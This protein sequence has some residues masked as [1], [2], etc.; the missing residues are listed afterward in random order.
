MGKATEA[1]NTL[2]AVLDRMEVAYAIGG[3]VASSSH[4]VPRTTLD[5][6]IVVDMKLDQVDEFVAAV[7]DK[8]YADADMIREAFARGRAANLIHF[9][10]A[11]KFDLFPK[12]DDDY[13]DAEFRRRMCRE[14]RPDG[15]EAVECTF[16]SPEDTLLR[17][18]E[19][20]RKGG[21]SPERQWNDVRGI[22]DAGGSG[23]DL[24]YMRKWA[25]P[26]GVADLLERLLAE[27]GSRSIDGE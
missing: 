14:V 7:E 10:S 18:L 5:V 3:S 19:W 27:A 6:D 17:K 15:S 8:F 23:L 25:G 1:L 11:W 13:S 22:R 24:A 20:Y 26:L 2:L 9:R 12:R 21:G 16:A 4:G